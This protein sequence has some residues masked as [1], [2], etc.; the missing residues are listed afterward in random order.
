M[1]RLEKS[2]SQRILFLLEYLDLP[3]NLKIY[4]RGS[5]KLAD[6]ALKKVHPLGKSPVITIEQDNL[7]EPL[8][9]AESGLVVEYLVE[10]FGGDEKGLVPKK[11]REGKDGQIGGET[12]EWLRYR[13]FMHYAEGSLIGL[14]VMGLL[15][16]RRSPTPPS[17]RFSNTF[18]CTL[19]SLTPSRNP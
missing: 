13:Y 8:V 11:W 9:L 6:P 12:D 7:S 18:L 2:R 14:L 1:S 5:D 3:Y 17:S 4:K 19:R 15:V 10:H 16:G